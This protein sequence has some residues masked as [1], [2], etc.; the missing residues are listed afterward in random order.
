MKKKIVRF[1]LAI[2]LTVITIFLSIEASS[3]SIV[4]SSVFSMTEH[5]EIKLFVLLNSMTH[6][7]EEKLAGEIV[8]EHQ[9]VNGFT[10]NTHYILKLYRTLF[11]YR[12]NWEYDTII[13]DE[14]GVIV[15]CED[16]LGV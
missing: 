13:C 4:S 16:I 11:H 1:F 12:K 6:I 5:T 8:T 15:C 7:D 2:A 3:Y 14:N 9:A 10:N